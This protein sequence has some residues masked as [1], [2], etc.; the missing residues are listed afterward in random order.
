MA[1]VKQVLL[2]LMGLAY[3]SAGIMH[4]VNAA[5][6]IRIVPDYLPWHAGLVYVSGVCE[7]ALGVLVWL[8]ATREL[9]AWGIIA[10][11]I[12]VFPANIN[13]LVHRIPMQE[14]MPP[15]VLALWLRL[16]LQ[17]VLIAWAWWYTRS[18]AAAARR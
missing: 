15:N 18:D 2:W 6:F 13:M 5:F 16:P 1:R 14:G 4:F 10:L 8:P 17:G 12:A 3:L 9:A 7:I 11:L